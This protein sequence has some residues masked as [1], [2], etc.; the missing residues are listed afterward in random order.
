MKD[1]NDLT[2]D[3]DIFEKVQI[4]KYLGATI[5]ASNNYWIAEIGSRSKRKEQVL[6]LLNTSNQRNSPNF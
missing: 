2:L 3:N 1:I 5:T 4:F 6:H